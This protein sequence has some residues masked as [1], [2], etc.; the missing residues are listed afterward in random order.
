[1]IEL[2]SDD[3]LL[4]DDDEREAVRDIVQFVRL[5]DCIEQNTLADEVLK[6][7]PDQFQRYMELIRYKPDF[8]K[9]QENVEK[10]KLAMLRKTNTKG[11]A[12]GDDEES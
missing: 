3:R 9:I 6:E 5:N 11:A 8:S 7:L 12:L 1:M 4:K 2:D 10:T